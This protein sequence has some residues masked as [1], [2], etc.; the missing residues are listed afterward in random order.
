MW[1]I[2]LLIDGEQSHRKVKKNIQK[3]YQAGNGTQQSDSRPAHYMINASRYSAG[4][5]VTTNNN[6]IGL[7]RDIDHIIQF[8]DN[9]GSL[10]K[11]SQ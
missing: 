4:N 3:I 10:K 5:V 6:A 9:D 11:S 7:R 8:Q 1:W 2:L